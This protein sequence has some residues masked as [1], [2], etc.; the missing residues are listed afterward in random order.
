M[1]NLVERVYPFFILEC[2]FNRELKKKLK[3]SA[4]VEVNVSNNNKANG[5]Y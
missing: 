5:T 2:D 4:I 1:F 3:W